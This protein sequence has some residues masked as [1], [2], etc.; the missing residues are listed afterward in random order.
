LQ[1]ST[2]EHDDRVNTVEDSWVSIDPLLF[3]GMRTP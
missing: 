3:Q 2:L 1:V